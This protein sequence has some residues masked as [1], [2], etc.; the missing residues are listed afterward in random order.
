MTGKRTFRV[1]LAIAAL[2]LTAAGAGAAKGP[3]AGAPYVF[4]GQLLASPPANATAV[5][6]AVAGGNHL[7][8]KKMLGSSVNQTFTVGTGTEF[9]KWSN[10]IPTV[11]HSNDLTAGDWVTVRVRAPRAATLAEVESHPA[12]IVAD[13]VKEP[14]PPGKPLYLF[15]GTL[16]S[17]AG[18]TSVTL[19]VRGGNR[20][21]LR[22]LIGSGRQQTFTF[23]QDTIFLLW[24]G[25]V[26][27][28]V[29]PAQLEVGDRVTVRIRAAK[30]STLA[31]VES[32]PAARVAD[33]E[34]ANAK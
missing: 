5:S 28:V 27:T 10:G 2:A 22:L 30:G 32:T 3:G 9:L 13:R 34:P 24:Q 25:K 15:R 6:V 33:H 29:T 20:H 14:T 17:P 18:A 23:G 7:A 11:V 1:A 19:N 12:G 31:Q 8:L 4:R 21:A 26:P 16:A